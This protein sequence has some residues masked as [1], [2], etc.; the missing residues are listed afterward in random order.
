[1][2]SDLRDKFSLFAPF[3]GFS[4]AGLALAGIVCGSLVWPDGGPRENEVAAGVSL[5][6][7]LTGIGMGIL[8]GFTAIA[9]HMVLNSRSADPR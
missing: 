1:M 8:L 5:L 4:A 2:D 6:I 3:A 7:A 9:L